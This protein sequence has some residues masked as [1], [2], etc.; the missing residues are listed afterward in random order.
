MSL[1]NPK[2][3]TLGKTFFYAPDFLLADFSG[4]SGGSFASADELNM[5]VASPVNYTW[6]N[7]NP[8]ALA[9]TAAFTVSE[10]GLTTVSGTIAAGGVALG[11]QSGSQ[12]P[13]G[14]DMTG[15]SFYTA[16]GDNLPHFV[17]FDGATATYTSAAL[18]IDQLY[19]A[20]V[21][22]TLTAAGVGASYDLTVTLTATGISQ[23][24]TY[25]GWTPHSE[26]SIPFV[27]IG[28]VSATSEMTL[29]VL[30]I[31]GTGLPSTCRG[32]VPG[33]S[34][35][36]RDST[37]KLTHAGIYKATGSASL[38]AQLHNEFKDAV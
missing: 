33:S 2:D 14:A 1:A 15:V 8:D 16:Q 27:A 22:F 26:V 10:S 23:N 5:G 25:T 29:D 9:V 19:S 34:E 13:A 28:A 17:I 32:P 6:K 12:D 20:V 37:A 7:L 38:A 24:H 18:T 36:L 35:V 11:K 3:C 4:N 30:Y 31:V 21:T